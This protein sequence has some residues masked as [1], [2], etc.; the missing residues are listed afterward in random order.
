[1]QFLYQS[2]SSLGRRIQFFEASLKSFVIHGACCY[3]LTDMRNVIGVASSMR[4]DLCYL[5]D[6]LCLSSR[7]AG[8]AA[9]C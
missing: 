7:L 6:D 1:M 5:S 2:K 3:L 9:E 4:Y 8:V